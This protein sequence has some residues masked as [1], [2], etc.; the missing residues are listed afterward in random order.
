MAVSTTISKNGSKG[1][2]KYTLTVTETATSSANNTSTI[3]I[4][5]TLS[6]VSTG[7]DWE[8]HSSVKGTVTVNGTTYSWTCPTYNGS[9]TVTLVSKTQTITHNADGSK[10]IS[11]SFSCQADTSYDYLPGT[12]SGS[13]SL[14]LTTLP[15]ESTLS[16][17][18]TKKLGNTVTLNV[19]RASTSFTHT[20]KATCGSASDTIVTKGSSTS[21]SY[22]LPVEWAAQN[23][24]GTT[25][26]ITFT[27][28]TYS[29]STKIGS[30]K[31]T[32]IS[33][34]IQAAAKPTV[35]SVTVEAGDTTSA[36]HLTQYG[37]YVQGK[38]KVK[39]TVAASESYGS[40][41]KSWNISCDDK[42]YTQ[43]PATTSV[44][45]AAG[46]LTAKAKVTD[47]RGRTSDEVT[48][49]GFTVLAYSAPTI[50]AA[51]HRCDAQGVESM[52]GSNCEVTWTG[53]MSSL[54]SGNTGTVT[55]RYKQTAAENYTE[56]TGQSL[57]GS[58]IFEADD[59]KTY[60][61][62]VVLED[63]FTVVSVS[64]KLSTASVPIH[65]PKSG[66][67]IAIGKLA[68]RDGLDLGWELWVKDIDFTLSA[69]EYSDLA[70]R[71]GVTV[72]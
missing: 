43:S 8:D 42:T 71:L 65:F 11:M 25:V 13:G 20:I 21:I 32:T 59:D 10:Q 34:T 5:F 12:A 19:T 39:I 62:I 58:Y 36:G 22:T 69:Q 54:N 64:A 41:I 38:S 16:V 31:T 49:A 48:S 68:T 46:T 14:T 57:S 66:N 47:A 30:S 2:H 50:K 17:S 28:T 26:S 67:G 53:S 15:R 72:D 27:I 70:Q 37:A 45:S 33:A 60:D 4:K 56:V 35:T 18:G 3:S 52:T 6:P 44:L 1:H 7:W 9:S 24:T 29:G 40:A 61:V 51:V 23:T 63:D 55:V